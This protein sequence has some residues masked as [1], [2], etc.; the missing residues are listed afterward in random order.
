MRKLLL[1]ASLATLCLIGQAFVLK[2]TNIPE[3]LKGTPLTVKSQLDNRTL[4]S[5]NIEGSAAELHGTVNDVELCKVGYNLPVDGGIATYFS[6]VF[7]NNNDTVWVTMTDIHKIGGTTRRG[8]EF[9]E[10]LQVALDSLNNLTAKFSKGEISHEDIHQLAGKYVKEQITENISNLY[11]GYMLAGSSSSI[12]PETWLTL[13]HQLPEEIAAYPRLAN[14]AT[15]LKSV[16]ETQ[17]GEM[18]KDFQCLTPERASVRLSDYVGKGKYTLLDFWAT[19]CGPCRQEAKETI[20]PI[21]EKYK[22]N[23]KFRVLSVMTSDSIDNHLKG[24]AKLNYPWQQLIDVD[25]VSGDLFGFNRIP[26]IVLLDPNGRIVKRDIR[27]EEI[28]Q[29]VETALN[30]E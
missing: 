8:G 7:I 16:I 26:F 17:E 12:D 5:L 19:W 6:D 15:R 22:D 20:L 1:T 23:D 18:F 25:D 27:G 3:E 13:Y 10:K 9:N 11:G 4:D 29:A 21:Y 2:V 28:W 24:L 30:N 14:T